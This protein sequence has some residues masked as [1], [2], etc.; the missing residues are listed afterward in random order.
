MGKFWIPVVFLFVAGIAFLLVAGICYNSLTDVY[1]TLAYYG[2][3]EKMVLENDK[4]VNLLF[5]LKVET[6][7][8]ATL[9]ILAFIV[10]VVL[11]VIFRKKS[12]SI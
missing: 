4:M 6:I 7:A 2:V 12:S 10:A 1:G 3:S 5:R 9:G 8:Y 11:A